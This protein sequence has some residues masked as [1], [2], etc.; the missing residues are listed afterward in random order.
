[1]SKSGIKV[2]PLWRLWFYLVIFAAGLLV[3][4]PGQG[5]SPTILSS[6]EFILPQEAEVGLDIEARSPGASWAMKGAE[7]SALLIEVDGQYNQDLILWAGE[8][9]F[10]YRVMLGRLASGKHRV[11]VRLNPAR[12]AP[13]A[14]R[15]IVVALRPTPLSGN[16]ERTPDDLLAL[17]HAPVL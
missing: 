5:A 12:S 4:A 17:A 11:S 8:S 9:S 15:A 10:V 2:K 13:G 7:A 14:Q 6:K 1:M 3:S 16:S